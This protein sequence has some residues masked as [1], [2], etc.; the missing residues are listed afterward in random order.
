[1]TTN[2]PLKLM[3]T[4]SQWLAFKMESIFWLVYSVK[5]D[6]NIADKHLDN[7]ENNARDS[8]NKLPN[9]LKRS[10]KLSKKRKNKPNPKLSKKLNKRLKK[11]RFN[12]NKN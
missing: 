8:G 9:K 2:N 11:S 7:A 3:A 4:K 6:N 5:E 10:L 1:M 12:P